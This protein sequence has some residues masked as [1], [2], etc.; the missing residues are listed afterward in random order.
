VAISM[1]TLLDLDTLSIK[2]A[3]DNLHAVENRRKKK[4]VS[5]GKDASEQVLLMEE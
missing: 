2:E 5:P 3:A 4:H 1:K